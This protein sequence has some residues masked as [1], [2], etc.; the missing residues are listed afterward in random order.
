MIQRSWVQSPL[1]AILDE[2]FF[3]FPCMKICQ[4]IS[5]KRVSS[6]TRMSF[7]SQEHLFWNERLLSSAWFCHHKPRNIKLFWIIIT[8]IFG[9]MLRQKVKFTLRITSSFSIKLSIEYKQGQ[10]KMSNDIKLKQ[11]KSKSVTEKQHR[12]FCSDNSSTKI[13]V[14]VKK[15][16]SCRFL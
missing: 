11:N 2:F 5:Q 12:S 10:K 13:Q 8:F 1:G 6:K 14:R 9:Y 4:M 15:F 3:A 16:S 7:W